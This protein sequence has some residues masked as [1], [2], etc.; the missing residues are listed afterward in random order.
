[1]IPVLFPLKQHLYIMEPHRDAGAVL[2]QVSFSLADSLRR[3]CCW[4]LRL[5]DRGSIPCGGNDG[6]FFS[7]PPRPNRLWGPPSQW[8]PGALAPG[9]K[10]PVL[11]FDHSPTS[12]AE[13]GMRRPIPPF[14]STSSW[15]GAW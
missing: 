3:T 13:S 11:E 9:V 14:P 15:S 6:I 8:V 7:S 12:S 2:I 1:V 5:D 10:R 4:K